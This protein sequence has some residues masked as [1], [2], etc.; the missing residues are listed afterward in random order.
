MMPG[1][2]VE[3]HV[4]SGED[5][6]LFSP[7]TAGIGEPD[8]ALAVASIAGRI[9]GNPTALVASYRYAFETLREVLF[10]CAPF[11]PCPAEKQS[12]KLVLLDQ[13]S[14]VVAVDRWACG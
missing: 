5:D 10:G 8:R 12:G 6:P 14:T 4:A 13:P 2:N 9:G 7:L 3:V 11:S 1:C